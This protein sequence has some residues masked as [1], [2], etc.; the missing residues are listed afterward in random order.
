MKIA[1]MILGFIIR[2]YLLVMIVSISFCLLVRT[3]FH[4]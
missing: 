3:W 2:V 1:E 4:P